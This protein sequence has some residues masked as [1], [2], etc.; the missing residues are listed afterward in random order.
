MKP[1]SQSLADA[2][3]IIRSIIPPNW[4]SLV[5]Q[6]DQPDG[7]EPTVHRSR[8]PGGIGEEPLMGEPV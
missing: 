2:D 3:A 8:W 6:D 5:L 7:D 4:T 1:L